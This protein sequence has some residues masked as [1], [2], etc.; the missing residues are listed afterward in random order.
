MLVI[1]RGSGHMAMGRNLRVL[2]D[3]SDI[4]ALRQHASIMVQREPGEHSVEAE[5]D[6][7]RSERVR[8]LLDAGHDTHVTVTV[9]PR[10]SL[11]VMLRRSRS[12]FAFDVSPAADRLPGEA[13]ALASPR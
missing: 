2:V 5:L 12:M 10:M 1:D 6:G 11:L 3:G 4:G 7:H 9:Y 13:P 8:L